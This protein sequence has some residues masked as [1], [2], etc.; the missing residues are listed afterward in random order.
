MHLHSFILCCLGCAC[1]H[2]YTT[3]PHKLQVC[4]T[5]LI[6]INMWASH[7]RPTLSR[8]RHG[9]LS[10]PFFACVLGVYP[11]VYC[12]RIPYSPTLASPHACGALLR[13]R[14]GKF[15]CITAL[16]RCILRV[17]RRHLIIPLCLQALCEWCVALCVG[18]RMNQLMHC[19][20]N[21]V[22]V[23]G[24]Q[25]LINP[26]LYCRTHC[27]FLSTHSCVAVYAC[28]RFAI[29]YQPTPVRVLG[30]QYL[31]NPLLAS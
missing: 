31:I 29:S 23:L 12:I 10:N 5:L 25:H 22:R 28:A 14:G 18:Y 6:P 16:Q 17:R 3:T 9:H 27:I 15:D 1:M 30:L 11:H 4:I 13:S 2:I 20:I 7:R 21:L 24:S 19:S 26:L 8:N